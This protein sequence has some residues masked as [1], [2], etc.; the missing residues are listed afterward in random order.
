MG[1]GF[2]ISILPGWFSFSLFYKNSVSYIFNVIWLFN[3]TGAKKNCCQVWAVFNLCKWAATANG[4]EDSVTLLKMKGEKLFLNYDCTYYILY[5]FFFIWFYILIFFYFPKQLTHTNTCFN[6]SSHIFLG[7]RT[8][9]LGVHENVKCN[10]GL[11]SFDCLLYALFDK[12]VIVFVFL[13]CFIWSLWK[14][15]QN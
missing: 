2:I 4:S 9:K 12:S 3:A 10:T 8:H 7:N 1:F 5:F 6:H 13:M 11:H 15:E 14:T